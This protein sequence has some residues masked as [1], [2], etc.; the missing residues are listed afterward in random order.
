MKYQG[1]ITDD[2]VKEKK[3]MLEKSQHYTNSS[4]EIE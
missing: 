2:F 1:S 3:Y 4:G